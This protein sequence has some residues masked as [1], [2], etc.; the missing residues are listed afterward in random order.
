MTNTLAYSALLTQTKEFYNFLMPASHF[1]KMARNALRF[2]DKHSSLFCFTVRDKGKK[3]FITFLMP[4]S[5]FLK[6]LGMRLNFMRNTL[7][8]SPSV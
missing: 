5:L 4:A 2:N 3:S 8:Y 1:V 7:A 6:I